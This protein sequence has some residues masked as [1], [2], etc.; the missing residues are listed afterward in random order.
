MELAATERYWDGLALATNNLPRNTG[1]IYC[2]G[3]VVEMLLKVAYF[4]VTG[5]ADAQN[6][7][8]GPLAAM[9][10]QA[11]WRGR[12]LHDLQGLVSLLIDVRQTL[13]IAFDPAVAAQ[14]LWYVLTV[15]AHWRE[16]LRYK[17]T[18]ALEEELHEVYYSVEWIWEHRDLL[19]S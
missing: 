6:L 17:H 10:T 19:W 9:R 14:M 11:A 12:N 7:N 5:V 1:A 13:G 4:R 16:T 18:P 3:Y 2:F 8:V 15:D